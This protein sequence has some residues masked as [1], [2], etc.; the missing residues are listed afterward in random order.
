MLLDPMLVLVVGPSCSGK[1]TLLRMAATHFLGNDDVVFPRR[2]VTRPPG[3][4]EDHA[5]LDF[6]QFA[7]AR[8]R[9][10]FVLDWEAHEL[11][12]AIPRAEMAGKIAVCNVS[13]TVIANA[14]QM[15]A[16][17]RVVLVTAPLEVLNARLQARGREVMADGRLHRQIEIEPPDLTIDNIGDPAEGAG[18]LIGYIEALCEE[19]RNKG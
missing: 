10:E 18:L 13:R 19:V 4:W 8:Q 9:G 14:R 12:Y 17:T 3:P 7:E 6:D 5:S 1:D 15:F 2:V 11:F 16:Q